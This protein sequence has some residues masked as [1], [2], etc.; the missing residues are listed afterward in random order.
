MT[1]DGALMTNTWGLAYSSL[2]GTALGVEGIKEYRVVTNAPSAEYGLTMGSQSVLV[3][4]GGT[5]SLHGSLFEYIRNNALDAR[6][7]FEPLDTANANGCGT[8]KLFSFACKRDGPFHQ[9]NFGASLG[10]PIQKNKTFIFGAYEGIRRNRGLGTQTTT[11]P[12]GCFVNGVVPNVIANNSCINGSAAAP[13]TVGSAL[14]PGDTHSLAVLQ[15]VIK[16]FPAPNALITASATSTAT[17]I[18]LN[19]SFANPEDS[20]ENYGQL[21]LDHNFSNSDAAFIRLTEDI[22]DQTRL[23]NASGAFA[24]TSYPTIHNVNHGVYAFITGSESHIF[25]P[26]FLNTARFSLTRASYDVETNSIATNLVADPTQVF[27]QATP[28]TFSYANPANPSQPFSGSVSAY[29]HVVG[30][31]PSRLDSFTWSDDLF[32]TKGKHALKF[33]TMINHEHYHLAVSAFQEGTVTFNTLS[34]FF[35]GRYLTFGATT[36]SGGAGSQTPLGGPANLQRDPSL[37]TFGFYT[38][39]D[40]RVTSR[41]VLNLGL[42][43]EFNTDPVFPNN[44]NWNLHNVLTDTAPT[45]GN[46]ILNHSMHNFSPRVGFAWDVTGKGTLSV[47]GGGGVYYDH[48]CPGKLLQ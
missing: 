42:R 2:I 36:S 12:P 39:D 7:F 22:S 6:N 4:K 15:S 32:W 11:L 44:T 31:G 41:L 40:Y 17:P 30:T 43:Y 27:G 10:G 29:G 5:N 25:S 18:R 19:Y 48:C 35:A 37:N 45:Q 26:T 13:I 24:S 46:V 16:L 21:R 47:R 23:G 3:S 34:D 14:A 8:D 38:Q 28:G 1:I 9:N 33:G 20:K